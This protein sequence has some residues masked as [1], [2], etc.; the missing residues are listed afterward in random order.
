M[1]VT[2]VSGGDNAPATVTLKG[3]LDLATTPMVDA[4]IDQLLNQGE[5]DVVVDL[6]QV[7]FCDSMGI[8]A[9]VRAKRRCERLG[10]TFVISSVEGEVEQIIRIAGLLD[11]L[12]SSR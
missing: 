11:I 9:L 2:V 5:V 10:G 7:T 3:D 12:T 6:R 4:H 1:E 8:N